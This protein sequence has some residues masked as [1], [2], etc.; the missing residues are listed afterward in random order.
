M[1]KERD[2]TKQARLRGLLLERAAKLKSS[3]GPA[4]SKPGPENIVPPMG[5]S[6]AAQDS[7]PVSDA[8]TCSQ[9]SRLVPVHGTVSSSLLPDHRH[10]IISVAD[11]NYGRLSPPKSDAAQD[12]HTGGQSLANAPE[13]G[14]GPSQNHGVVQSG[15]ALPLIPKPTQTHYLPPVART[16][17]GVIG[18]GVQGGGSFGNPAPRSSIQPSTATEPIHF[19]REAA[20]KVEDSISA[21]FRESLD[22]KERPEKSELHSS[23]QILSHECQI[24]RF[25]RTYPAMA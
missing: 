8:A 14:A 2:I 15:H 4:P 17:M 10:R 18:P 23:P 21:A 25:N 5:P 1:D 13:N 22:Q 12:A 19:N 11:P 9:P 16:L 7:G 6:K 3:P 20:V 24:R